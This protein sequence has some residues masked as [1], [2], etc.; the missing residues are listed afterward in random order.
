M[1]HYITEIWIDTL[2]HLSD[3][4][5]SLNEKK[6]QHLMIT[7]KNGSGK[8]S[9]LLAIQK[10]LRAINN[11]ELK[12]LTLVYIP[13]LKKVEEKIEHAEAESEKQKIEKESELNMNL[14]Q[15]YQDGVRIRFNVDSN[16]TLDELYKEGDFI[17]A[18][19][20]AHRKT[21]IVRAQGVEDIRLNNS[22]T[23]EEEPGNLLLKYMVH[24]KTQQA[25]AKNEGDMETAE[26][27]QKWFER[28]EGALRTLL[29]D[30]S[31]F[32]E[33]DYKEYD[34]KSYLQNTACPCYCRGIL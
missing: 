8:T 4:T 12:A 22:Y 28:F 15:K 10:Y 27:I 17:T 29:D 19:F 6:R 21:Q 26:K 13:W 5:I 32:L 18:F 9:L 24:L 30:D 3:I 14:I 1:E 16:S 23:M 2:R 11:G 7:G 31:L 20:P 34:F 25:Y 33:Y